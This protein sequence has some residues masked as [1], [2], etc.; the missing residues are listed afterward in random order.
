MCFHIVWHIFP[1]E[2]YV[3]KPTYRTRDANINNELYSRLMIL[4]KYDG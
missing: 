3:G 2:L 4:L 1:V